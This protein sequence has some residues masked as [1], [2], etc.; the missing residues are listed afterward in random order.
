VT[1]R[2]GWSRLRRALAWTGLALIVGLFL[3]VA[4]SSEVRFV[5]RAA[6]EEGGI[7][8]HR[9]PLARWRRTPPR[10]RRAAG[11]FSW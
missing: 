9:R 11:S 2:P 3:A 5:L 8:I 4:V 10:R 7:L 1:G 6:W